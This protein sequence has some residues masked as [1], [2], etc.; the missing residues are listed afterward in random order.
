MIDDVVPCLLC[1]RLP[2]P[3]DDDEASYIH[4]ET[5]TRGLELISLLQI[6]LVVV[7]PSGGK[8]RITIE[9]FVRRM[10]VISP[11]LKWAMACDP[12]AGQTLTRQDELAARC[13]GAMAVVDDVG[14]FSELRL[15]AMDFMP[16]TQ[17][18]ISQRRLIQSA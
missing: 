13:N 12:Q 3:Q 7:G 17:P 15:L 9:Q 14:D 8:D 11:W 1:V 16:R 18:S 6:A 2:V 4:A 5:L 10:R